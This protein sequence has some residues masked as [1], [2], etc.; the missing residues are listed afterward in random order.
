MF[1]TDRCHQLDDPWRD[2]AMAV[3]FHEE[4]GSLRRDPGRPHGRVRSTVSLRSAI[5]GGAGRTRRRGIGA[6]ADIPWRQPRQA[7]TS[8]CSRAACA[9]RACRSRGFVEAA[10]STPIRRC[11]TRV[12]LSVRDQAGGLVGQPRRDARRH[13]PENSRRRR[14]DYARCCRARTF[15]RFAAASSDT[16]PGR[17][18]HRGPRVRDRRRDD[19]RRAAACLRSS[20]SPIRSTARSS[21]RRS[22]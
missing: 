8:S 4:A 3:R 12:S 2:A 1:A 7:S 16:R 13:T 11:T 17:R 20:T 6:A 5:A 19:R 15:A 10:Q 14:R 18:V 22:T 21:R 9:R